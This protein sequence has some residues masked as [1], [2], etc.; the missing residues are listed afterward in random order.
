MD[1]LLCMRDFYKDLT[2]K[3]NT[4]PALQRFYIWQEREGFYQNILP[5]ETFDFDSTG[6]IQFHA[7]QKGGRV[8]KL[9]PLHDLT[10]L[11]ETD[12]T[13]AM[14]EP[15]TQ[16]IFL[17]IGSSKNGNA[18]ITLKSGLRLEVPNGITYGLVIR[19]DKED[20]EIA[21]RHSAKEREVA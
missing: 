19:R 16:E 5:Y 21:I 12:M 11:K 2:I 18:S 3:S 4:Y 17:E 8:N 14:T 7:K 20:F 9:I 6:G 1:F 13:Q 10:P 15:D